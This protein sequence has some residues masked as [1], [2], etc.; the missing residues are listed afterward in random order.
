MGVVRVFLFLFLVQSSF[1]DQANYDL[2]VQVLGGKANK[3]NAIISLFDSEDKFLKIPLKME[4]VSFGDSGSL[5][6]IFRE[7]PSGIYAISVVHDED[8]NGEL[9]TNFFGIPTELIGFSNNA[10][11]RFGPPSFEKAA[12]DLSES[13]TVTITLGKAKK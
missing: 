12:F 2:K 9:N 6:I 7:I 3:G 8:N 13:K 4:K 10:S 11:S 5:E 1:V